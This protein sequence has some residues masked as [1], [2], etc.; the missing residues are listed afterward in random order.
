MG[1]IVV[2]KREWE[3][4]LKVKL[5]DDNFLKLIKL[6]VYGFKKYYEFKIV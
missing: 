3:K 4:R 2:L 1:I 6:L 5:L